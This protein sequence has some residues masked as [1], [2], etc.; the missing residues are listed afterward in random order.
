MSDPLAGLA[1]EDR[2]LLEEEGF[3]KWLDPM[4]AT[5]VDDPFSDPDWI[6]ERKLDGERCL[7]YVEGGGAR[8]YSRNRKDITATYP[9]LAEALSDGPEMVVDGEVVAFDGDTTSF[10]RL[11]GR[12]QI[13]SAERA[14]QSGV[15]VFYY[16]F[17]IMH[18]DGQN[19]RGLPLR[20][21]KQILLR[22][23]SFEDPLR[24][25][26]HRNEDGEDFYEKACRSGW[27]GLI[28]K[29]ANSTYEGTRSRNWL[30]FKCVEQQ[31]FVVGGYTDPKGSRKGFGALLIGY[32]DNGS[33]V[34]A[35]KV[36]T[37]YD[38]DA[39]VRLVSTLDDIA[40]DDSPFSGRG[41]PRDAH[42]VRPEMVVE[43]G[44][45]EWTTD[46]RL[47]HPRFLGERRDKSAD[48]VV[49]EAPK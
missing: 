36:G 33:L 46:G 18:I 27:E 37:G 35:G 20:S 49:R 39:L 4:L 9:E 41:V 29:D 7:A 8:L 17:D 3:P 5:L 2:S 48:E 45:T 23:L 38:E 13:R 11:Q 43:V 47:R 15:A 25:S 31:E 14:R 22:S 24:F 40:I 32:N 21:R 28:A 34:Y 30:K 1:E 12:M 19:V 44:F 6:Y 26:S 42:W 10:Q 16:L